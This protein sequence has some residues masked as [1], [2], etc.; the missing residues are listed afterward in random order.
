MRFLVLGPLEVIGEGGEPLPISG[1]KE[2]TI[3]ADLIA[4]AGRVVSVDDLIDTGEDVPQVSVA[5]VFDVRAREPLALAE[6]P[7]RIGKEDEVAGTREES[8]Q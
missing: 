3:L 6:A 4:R 8:R 1:S 7:A 2:R 5:E